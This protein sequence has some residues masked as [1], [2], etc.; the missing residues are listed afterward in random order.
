MVLKKGFNFYIHKRVVRNICVCMCVS[1]RM[2]V[3]VCV[4]FQL[5]LTDILI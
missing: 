2:C 4:C 1:V 5:K 3:C